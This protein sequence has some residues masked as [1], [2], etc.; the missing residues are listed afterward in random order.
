MVSPYIPFLSLAL[1]PNLF[2]NFKKFIL[3]CWYTFFHFISSLSFFFSLRHFTRIFKV[4]FSLCFVCAC[5]LCSDTGVYMQRCVLKQ[6]M[7]VGKTLILHCFS[8]LML[9]RLLLFGLNLL[10]PVPASLRS[11][12]PHCTLN[13]SFTERNIRRNVV[14]LK[15]SAS[16]SFSSHY[17]HLQVPSCVTSMRDKA[18]YDVPNGGAYR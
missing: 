15:E 6:G 7:C 16:F 2:A 11:S 8:H 14:R 10:L 12:Y 18:Q 17:F 3:S 1:S 9:C 5:V 13:G 4:W